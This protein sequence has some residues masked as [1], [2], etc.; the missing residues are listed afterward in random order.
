M[1]KKPTKQ[2]KAGMS[3]RLSMAMEN[4]L[5]SIFRLQE[6]GN[7][8]TVTQLAEHLKTLPEAEGLGT[9]L[10]SVGA[11]VKRMEREGFVKIDLK[12]KQV[13]F[14]TA[15]FINAETIVR[16]HRLAERLVVDM[17][18]V[19]LYM[20]HTVAHL[21]E[22]AFDEYLE[23][24][25]LAKLGNP[26]ISPYGYPIPGSNYV[27]NKKAHTLSSSEPNSKFLVDRIPVDDQS[28]LK[29]LVE[30][31]VI[32]GKIGTVK[33]INKSAGTISIICSGT[34]SVF[35]LSVG[36]LIWVIPT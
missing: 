13:T 25:I 14:T 6:E 28:L 23:T 21:L 22:H 4:Y 30:T 1:A 33:E 32:P 11:M 26:S 16:R 7:T 12:N 29:Y 34:E 36:N 8:V 19:E 9:S 15:G 27:I 10:P 31:N 18:G 17:F 2:N 20:A 24:K 5:L 35:G 3:V